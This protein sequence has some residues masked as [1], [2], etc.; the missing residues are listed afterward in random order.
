MV[1]DDTAHVGRRLREIRSWRGMTMK[2]CAELAGMSESHL[3]RI[4]RGERPVDRRAT[5]E[6]LANAL[7]VA[8]SE[9]VQTPWMAKDPHDSAAHAALV[10]IEAALDSYDLGDDPGVPVREWAAIAADLQR[11]VVMQ[12]DGDYAAQGSLTPKLLAELHAAFV[13]VPARRADVLRALIICF[14]SACLTTKR[15]GAHGLPQLAA[16]LAQR[17]AEELGSPEWRGYAVWL[18]G[19]ASEGQKNR[20]QQYL[21]AVRMADELVPALDSVDVQQA[22]G[23]LHLSAALAAAAQDDR[24]TAATHLAEAADLADRM[25]SEVGTFGRLWFGRVNVGMWR[26]TLTAEFGDI[27]RVAEVARGVHAD[28]IPSPVR[29][30]GFYM[31]LGR[32]LLRERATAEEGL[33]TLLQAEQLAPQRLRNDVYVREAVADRI[34]TA[35][36]DSTGRELRGLAHRMGLGA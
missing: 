33:A 16:R 23:M 34:R 4:E 5:L 18:R 9:L 36:R 27:D 29:R 2:A 32:S 21:R 35:R 8:P 10:D 7:R 24:D 15:L 1:D 22:Y 11:L 3:S 25:D 31:D 6:A 30:A 19:S 28:V 14:K 20:H 13:K 26:T 12:E 17:C